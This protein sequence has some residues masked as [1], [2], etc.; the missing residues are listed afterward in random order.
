MMLEMLNLFI[1]DIPY[2]VEKIKE[3]A[4]EKNMKSLGTESHKLKPTLQY[5]GLNEMYEL[6]KKLEAAGK[7]DEFSNE[8]DILV[9]DLV[10]NLNISLPCLKQLQKNLSDIFIYHLQVLNFIC[11]IDFAFFNKTQ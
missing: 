3:A 6:V 8:I 7:S 5:V 4:E 1:E 10:N 9:Q 11:N 2:Q